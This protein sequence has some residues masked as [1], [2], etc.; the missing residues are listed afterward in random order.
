[1]ADT[2]GGVLSRQTRVDLALVAVGYALAVWVASGPALMDH[3]FGA[4]VFL[5]VT[6]YLLNMA[7][8][9]P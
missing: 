7:W 6:V 9:R 3:V 2:A 8:R 4:L 1:M 5:V